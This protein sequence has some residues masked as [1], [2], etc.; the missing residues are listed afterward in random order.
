MQ[1]FADRQPTAALLDVPAPN[2]VSSIQQNITNQESWTL[3]ASVNATVARYDVT[4]QDY[5]H[6]DTSWR[7][8][9]TEAEILLSY[10]LFQS[11]NMNLGMIVDEQP[12]S[13]GNYSPYCLIS[14][15]SSA[16]VPSL[17]TFEINDRHSDEF[18]RSSP[19]KFDI[20]RETCTGTWEITKTDLRLVESSYS[21]TPTS[22]RSLT[23]T[24]PFYLDALPVMYNT[25][26]EYSPQGPRNASHWRRPA[27]VMSVATMYWARSAYINPYLSADYMNNPELYY[28]A[29]NETL[30]S[31]NATL[32]AHCFS[33]LCSTCN[34]F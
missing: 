32:H 12:A 23:N 25:I 31:T 3:S 28:P 5:H 7:Q 18:R 34:L 2:Y 30:S 16:Q 10:Q 24:V 33:I 8:L 22:H 11:K 17:Q 9:F 29:T 20:Q 27:I 14:Y 15:Y 13:S 26:R 21:H 19:M 1:Y 4:S 6:N